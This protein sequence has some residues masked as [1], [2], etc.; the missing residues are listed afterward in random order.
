LAFGP[1]LRFV[2]N[3]Q[4]LNGAY[5]GTFDC[6][7]LPWT[8]GPQHVAIEVDVADGKASYS[9]SV[10][11]SDNSAVVGTETGTGS[12]DAD[13]AIRLTGGWHGKRDGYEGIY[14]GKLTA[15]G[16]S[17]RGTQ[18]WNYEGKNYSRECSMTLKR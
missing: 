3:A 10:Y 7:K 1:S 14:T 18:N 6:A 16:G 12:V 13:G 11:N 9:R 4:V 5:K 2:A 8:K 17:L 15:A